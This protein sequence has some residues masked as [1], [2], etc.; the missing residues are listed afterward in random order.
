MTL[1]LLCDNEATQYLAFN[2]D[3]MTQ[4]LGFNVDEI[5]SF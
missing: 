5:F 4:C 3:E 1:V 2:V